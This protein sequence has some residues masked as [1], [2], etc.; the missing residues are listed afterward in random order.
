MDA[1]Y[2]L[3]KWQ[4]GRIG[5]HQAKVNSRLKKFW[6]LLD[7]SKSGRVLVPLCGKSLDMLWLHE[8]GHEV[9][10]VELSESA[11]RS[12][13]EENELTFSEATHS[14]H[15]VLHGTGAAAGISLMQADLFNLNPTDV[16]L[17]SS[18]YDRASMVAMPPELRGSYTS[19]IARLVPSGAQGLLISMSYDESEMSGPPFS[20]PDRDVRAS[21]SECFE[22][23]ELSH[24]NG[25]E[26]RGN[27]ADNGLSTLEERV[28][29]L[30][31][32]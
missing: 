22:I 14:G 7:V 27:L 1:D 30:R 19:A 25:P 3:S 9:L 18:V 16:G 17:I 6:P 12:F 24:S 11:L 23:F 13:F 5:F 8:L 31:R 26:I 20:V 32:L 4:Q 2:W 28:Y 29:R 10:G 21:L 15:K